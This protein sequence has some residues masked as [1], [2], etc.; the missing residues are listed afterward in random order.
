LDLT[1]K[2]FIIASLFIGTDFFLYETVKDIVYIRVVRSNP[3]HTNTSSD[4]L[5]RG[6]HEIFNHRLSKRELRKIFENKVWQK[7]ETFHDY[8]H[9][10]MILVN[11]VLIDENEIILSS[12]AYQLKV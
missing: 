8:V 12:M 10:K 11:R 6:L 3:T 7:N 9:A 2:I 1:Y 5:L 4:D